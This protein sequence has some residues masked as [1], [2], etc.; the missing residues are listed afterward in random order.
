MMMK[1][2]L[3]LVMVLSMAGFAPAALQIEVS[4][5]KAMV[6]GQL[7]QNIFL[8]LSAGDGATLSNFTLGAAAPSASYMAASASDFTG[9]A[10]VPAGYQGEGWWLGA[11]QGE[12]YKTGTLLQAVVTVTTSQETR[13]WWEIVTEGCPTGWFRERTW[14]EITETQT[15]SLSLASLSADFSQGGLIQNLSL[16]SRNVISLTFVDGLC[17]EPATLALLGLGMALIRRRNSIK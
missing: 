1:K 3:V 8:I 16:N 4:G 11:I 10:P 5:G 17:P 2:V 15:G 9:L 6:T 14:T 13:T 7:D 12:A